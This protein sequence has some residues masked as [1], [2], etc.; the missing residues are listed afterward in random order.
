MSLPSIPSNA[1]NNTENFFWIDIIR[2]IVMLGVVT[3]HTAADVIT[4]WGRF[5]ESWWWSANIY[6]SLARGSV[7]V[8]VMVSG[9]LL[10][11]KQESYRDF[12]LK[13]F[14]RVIIPFIA[15]TILYLLARKIY[16]EPNLGL[17]EA[18]SRAANN[19]ASF[20]LWFLYVIVGLYL[21]TPIFRILIAFARGR[22]LF[23]FLALWFIVSSVLPFIDGLSNLFF[24]QHFTIKLS[25]E[26]MQGFI[27]YFVLGH[28][29]QKFAEKKLLQAAGVV[30]S[31][32]FF[33]CTA[34]TYC[35]SLYCHSFQQLFYH[36]MSPNVV[37]YSSAFF[38]VMKYGMPYFKNRIN[39]GFRNIIL[40][41]SKA[42]F[43]IYLIHPMILDTLNTG[44]L[45]FAL[46]GDTLHPAYMI[47]LTVFVVYFLSFLAVSVIQKI[48]YLRK[49]V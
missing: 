1:V 49:I 17:A 47:P 40:N 27:G 32:C 41:L 8:F 14:N 15:W 31:L 36:N 2:A 34:G 29:L 22:D 5:P 45:G 3:V 28:V 44:R 46:R 39:S 37:F 26:P 43:G 12:F 4:E 48:P 7:P 30:W 18:L 6:D 33:I 9:A 21:L 25:C 16:L 38:I 35:L 13:R 10:L 42:S 24:H 11:P 23:Y 20:H 19:K